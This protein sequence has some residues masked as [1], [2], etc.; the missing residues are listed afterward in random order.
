[1]SGGRKTGIEKAVDDPPEIVALPHCGLSEPLV[2]DHPLPLELK[3]V[4]VLAVT[5]ICC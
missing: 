1:V 3:L 4:K 2:H 5:H